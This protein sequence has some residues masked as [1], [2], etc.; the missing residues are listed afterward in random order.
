LSLWL[1]QYVHILALS[2]T[3]FHWPGFWLFADAW[4]VP[5]HVTRRRYF[6]ADLSA[7]RDQ[8]GHGFPKMVEDGFTDGGELSVMKIVGFAADG[9]KGDELGISHYLRRTPPFRRARS[10][11]ALRGWG[12]AARC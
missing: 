11:L 6:N 4:I 7:G 5:V 3:Q 2:R 1:K 10:G 12:R 9:P 8:D